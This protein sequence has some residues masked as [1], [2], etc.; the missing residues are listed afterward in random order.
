MKIQMIGDS[1]GSAYPHFVCHV[2]RKPIVDVRFGLVVWFNPE[3]KPGGVCDGFVVH[4]RECDKKLQADHG[5]RGRFDEG[6]STELYYFAQ[7][8]FEHPSRKS[9]SG[10]PLTEFIG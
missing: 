2:C 10:G 7:L 8:T 4:K 6:Q 3:L 1:G 9:G 5:S